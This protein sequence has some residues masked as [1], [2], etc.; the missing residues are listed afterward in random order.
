MI[1]GEGSMNL[2]ASMGLPGAIHGIE[3]REAEVLRYDEM[4]LDVA[5]GRVLVGEIAH[6]RWRLEMLRLND[7]CR[8]LAVQAIEDAA[9]RILGESWEVS[10]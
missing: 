9:W 2:P 1:L 10:S 3:V 5:G 6:F 4:V 7:R 8:K